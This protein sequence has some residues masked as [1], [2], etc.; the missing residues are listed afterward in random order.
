[1]LISTKAVGNVKAGDAVESAPDK[2]GP[3]KS[4]LNQSNDGRVHANLSCIRCHCK[5][6]ML[7]APKD[8]ARDT[9]TIKNGL[10]L[11]DPD[12][13]VLLELESKY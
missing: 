10:R 8:W 11:S 5:K 7:L 12:K 3:D 9:F 2:I 1:A 13:H 4:P 6:G